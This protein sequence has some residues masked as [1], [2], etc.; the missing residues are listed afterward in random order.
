LGLRKFN[1]EF[2]CFLVKYIKGRGQT[3]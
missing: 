3:E 2:C 1:I